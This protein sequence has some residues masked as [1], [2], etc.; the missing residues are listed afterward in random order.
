MKKAHHKPEKV[1]L[2]TETSAD[3]ETKSILVGFPSSLVNYSIHTL[4]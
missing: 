3:F 4:L 1:F 2:N